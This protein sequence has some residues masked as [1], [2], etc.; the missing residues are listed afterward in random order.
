MIHHYI[1]IIIRYIE[2]GSAYLGDYLIL[3]VF[4]AALLE[5]TPIIGTLTP[6]TLFL[7]LFGYAA[8]INETNLGIIVLVAAIGGVLGDLIGYAIGKY[9]GAW[10]IRNKKILKEVHI[11]QGR[12]FFSRH[13]GKSIF[14]GRFVGPIRPIVPLVAGSIHMNI[15]RFLFWNILSAFLWATIYLVGGY[16]FGSYARAI[17]SY[18]SEASIIIVGILAIF[19]YFIYRH[20]KRAKKVICE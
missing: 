10:M 13:G 12:S 5:S 16:F 18:V 19:G 9:A 20:K 11:E 4:V 8:F 6:G 3:V 14:I 7:L 15:R 17:E 2:E 1:D